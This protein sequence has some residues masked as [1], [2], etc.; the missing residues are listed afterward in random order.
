MRRISMEKVREI[1]R[2]NEQGDLSGRKIALALQISRPIV[3]E[4]I[5]KI[6]A[7]G[8]SYAAIRDMDDTSL[9]AA[10]EG[11]RKANN[12]RF[13]TLKEQ[14]P[15]IT[16][17]LKRPGVTLQCLWQEY[18]AMY[19]D[20][21]GYSQFCYHYQTWRNTTELTMHLEYKA[22]DKMFV[23]FTGKKLSIVDKD[24]GEVREI[25][26]FVAV[27][28]ASHYT[29]VEAVSS[30]K[31]H[32]WIRANQNAFHYFG[33]APKAVVPD[34]LKSAVKEA[35]KYEPDINPEYH[36]FARHYQTAILPARPGRPQ[37]KAIVEGAVKIV[38]QWIFAPLRD[39]LF[40]SLDELNGAI[41]E[42]L[43]VYN[44]KTMQKAGLSRREL[45]EETERDALQ[46]LPAEKYVLRNFKSLKVQF[47]YHIYLSDDKHH[48]SVP[49]RYRGKQVTVIYSESTVEICYQ[50]KRL[51]LHKRDRKPNGYTT[52]TEHMPSHHKLQ[53]EWSPQR[54]LAWAANIGQ[55]T[56]AVVTNILNQCEHPEQ[57]F[58]SC[59]GILNLTKD[60]EKE[61]INKACKLA[62]SFQN[63]TLKG[64]RNILKNNM[65][66]QQLDCFT[67]LPEHGN[68]RGNEYYS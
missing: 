27:L 34:C 46:P 6:A 61:R 36:H 50:N 66:N 21:Y 44:N 13:N 68:L 63:Y 15:C 10:I 54:F 9:L 3:A 40:H 30:Q 56:Q 11:S 39:R 58:K 52:L 38:Y 59:L 17:E 42:Q 8:L 12:E 32:D 5:H 22:G 48:Y 37:D 33:G 47:N 26:V 29:Y 64:I 16:K 14:F 24:T 67:A 28:A 60:Y 20:G 45:F 31:K 55:Y 4:Y 53:A 7:A 43:R 2:L 18:R 51:A 65:E 62:V 35:D 25:E 23:D 49:Y 57:G 19:P 41:T 1:I